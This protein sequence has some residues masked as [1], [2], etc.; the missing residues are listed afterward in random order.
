MSLQ[1]PLSRVLGLG[2]AKDGVGHWWWQ[3]LTAVALVPLGLWFVFAVLHLQ[4]GDH[5]AAV[6]WLHSPMQAALLILFSVIVCWHAFLGLQVVVE[7]YVHTEWL[8]VTVLI[9]LKMV[10]ALLLV[11]TV[12][13][14]LRIFLSS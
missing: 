6:Q 4:S 5:T 11:V 14:I 12:L 9:V 3:R 1:S 13:M 10:L 2:S 7:D 8:K